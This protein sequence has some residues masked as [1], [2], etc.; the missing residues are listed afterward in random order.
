MYSAGQSRRCVQ[1]GR[2]KFWG[3]VLCWAVNAEPQ[4]DGPAYLALPVAVSPCTAQRG[5]EMGFDWIDAQPALI[6]LDGGPGADVIQ[7][8]L[9]APES[10]DRESGRVLNFRERE[11]KRTVTVLDQPAFGRPVGADRVGVEMRSTRSTSGLTDIR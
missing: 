11:F 7:N 5:R 8:L 10:F 2:D 3:L 4:K 1:N 6:P 9:D